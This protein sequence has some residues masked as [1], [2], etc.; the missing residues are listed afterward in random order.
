MKKIIVLG[1]TGFVGTHVCEKLVR[2]GWQVT[3]PTRRRSNADAVMHLPGLT[4]QEFDV[5]DEAALTQA[6]AGHDALVNLVAILHGT[7]AAFE[8]VHVALPQKIAHACLAAGVAQVVHVSALGADSLQ[9]TLAPSMYLRTKGEGEAVLVQAAMGG[10]AG[11][12]AQAGFDLSILRPSVIF[13]AEDKFLNL[14][15]KLQKMLPMV[16]LAGADAKFQPVWVQDV[17]TA[18]VRCLAGASAAPSPRVIEAFG[19]EILTLKQL[20]QIAAQLSGSGGGMGRLVIPLPAWAGRLQ[21]TVMG[22]APGEPMMSLDNLDSMKVDNVA[23]G[24]QPG[25]DSLGI[26]ASALRPIAKQYLGRR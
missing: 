7:Q 25:L 19:P 1:G 10:S 12:V 6:A 18:V 20:V 22:L 14:F 5:Q 15:A 2:E 21:A 11:D 17:A 23:T 13:G 16:P 9:P 3:V 24:K 26:K 8:H 4:V